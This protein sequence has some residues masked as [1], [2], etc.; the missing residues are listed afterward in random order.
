MKLGAHYVVS[1]SCKDRDTLS[2]LPV[3]NTNS[4]VIRSAQNPRVFVVELDWPDVIQVSRQC[5]QA[6]PLFVVPHFDFV[7]VTTRNKQWL[8]RVEV[9]TSHRSWEWAM[10][11]TLAYHHA[12]QIDQLT[13]LI[14]SPISVSH[15]YEVI[16]KPRSGEDEMQC[17]SHER[18]LFQRLKWRI[19]KTLAKVSTIFW[20]ANHVNTKSVTCICVAY[21][22]RAYTRSSRRGIQSTT[23]RRTFVGRFHFCN[24]S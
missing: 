20:V 5:E 9:H 16:S 12:H 18:S 14:C 23:H 22:F 1:M 8:C 24:R 11:R 7:I 6:P 3:P 15:H 4:L 19:P 10:R 2:R 17:P 21:M 13:S